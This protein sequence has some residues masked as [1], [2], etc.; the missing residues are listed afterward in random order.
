[1]WPD[2]TERLMLH[3]GVFAKKKNV[4]YSNVP[5]L[6]EI[7]QVKASKLSIHL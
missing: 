7:P 2:I 4:A 1:M 3:A 5:G 6:A